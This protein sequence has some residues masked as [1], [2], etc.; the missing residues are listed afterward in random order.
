[1]GELTP[2]PDKIGIFST[3]SLG[4][5]TYTPATNHTHHLPSFSSFGCPFKGR[6]FLLCA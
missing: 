5:P 6:G 4:R 1:M 2:V 3:G